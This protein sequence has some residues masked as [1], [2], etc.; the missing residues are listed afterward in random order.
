MTARYWLYH[1]FWIGIDWLYPPICAGCGKSGTR[2]CRTCQTQVFKLQ[3]QICPRCGSYEP[4]G[5]LCVDCQ[6]NSLP[7]E[8]CLSWG[9][10]SGP[11]REAIHRLKYQNDVGLAEALANHLIEVFLVTGW[12]IDFITAVPLGLKR[13]NQRGYNQSSLLAL[14]LALAANVPFKPRAIARAR[15]TTSQVGLSAPLRKENVRGAFVARPSLVSN[16]A[17]LI[18]DDVTTTGATLNSCAQALLDG[19]A[20][21]VYCLTLAKSM[22]QDDIQIP[23]RVIHPSDGYLN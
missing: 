17:V 15:E 14:P 5:V 19:G 4:H 12:K 16:K 21:Q 10:Y 13:R 11:L 3:D 6:G 8:A 18:I 1:A 22:L 2:W 9:L 20:K 7:Y 23:S